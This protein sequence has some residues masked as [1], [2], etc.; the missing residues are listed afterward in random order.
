MRKILASLIVLIIIAAG[1]G[2]VLTAPKPLDPSVTAGLTGDPEHGEAIFNAGGCASCHA[3]PGAEGEAR[4]ILAGGK[5]FPSPFGTFYAPN[6]STSET[7]GIGA[8]T[9]ADLANAMLRGVS[10]AGQHYY[11]AF[12]YGSYAK[13]RPQDV[14]DLRA[15]LDTLPATETASRDHDVGFPFNIRRSLGGWKLLFFRDEFVMEEVNSEPLARGR[16]LVEA[17]GHCAECHTPRNALG[18][19]DT[20]RWLGGAPNPSGQG[21]IPNIT[22]GGLSWSEDEIAEYLASGFTP[23]FDVAGGEMAEVVQNTANLSATDRA[24]IAAYVKAV[25]AVE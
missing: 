14:A 1:V 13:A 19:L 21:T 18:G 2:W 24:A 6:I 7:A 8:W 5:A 16:Y 17:L 10:P 4:L 23:D 11:P 22:S 12:P 15:Y 3:A 9:V 20:S 25:P